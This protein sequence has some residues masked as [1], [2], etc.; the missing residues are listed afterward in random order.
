[1]SLESKS[2]EL[3]ALVSTY[4]TQWFLGD[5]SGLMKN[6]AAGRAQD[7]LGK[8]SSPMRQLYFLGGLLVSSDDSNGTDI[9]YTPDKWNQIVELLNEIER[10]Y[11]NLFFPKPD[12][13]IDEE[14]KK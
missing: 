2:Q 7:Q 12:E 8:L 6:I 14:W 5:L 10:E 1:M 13:E 9:Q 4:D 3:K 11:N